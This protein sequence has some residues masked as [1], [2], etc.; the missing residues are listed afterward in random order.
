[1]EVRAEDA[2]EGAREGARP[3]GPG[4]GAM[5]PGVGAP[6]PGAGGEGLGVPRPA[7]HRVSLALWFRDGDQGV[8]RV[9]GR[10]LQA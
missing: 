4:A 1:M 9:G 8:S 10:R 3:L 7:D 5:G 6:R 2:A